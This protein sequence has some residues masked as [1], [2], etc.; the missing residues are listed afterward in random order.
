MKESF[1]KQISFPTINSSEMNIILEYIHVES[2]KKN[3]L[4]VDNI[5]EVYFAADY[6]KI[7]GLQE[8]IITTVKNTLEK[9]Y[10]RNYSP[11]LLSKVAEIMPLSED[12]ALHN[13]LVK[14]IASTSLNY[15]EFGRLSITALEYL[16]YYTHE[17][18]IPFAT[19]EYEVF[20]YSAILAA[21][22]VSDDTYNTLMEHLPTLGQVEQ[23]IQV[24]NKLITNHKKVAKELE[25]LV[26]YID[27]KRMEKEQFDV[28]KPLKII[29]D[30]II[31]H[32]SESDLNNIRGIPIY[33]IKESDLLWDESAC[34]SNLIIENNGKV[35]QGSDNCRVNQSVRINIALENKG[36]YEWDVIIEKTCRRGEYV[37][38]GV[39]SENFDYES[40]AVNQRNGWVLGSNGYCIYSGSYCPSFK[41]DDD[42]RIT[43]HLDMNKRTCAF[44][45]NGIKY[46]EVPG[47]NNLPSKLYPLVSLCRYARIRIQAHQKN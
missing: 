5:V 9:N 35:V 44:T 21:K 17:K 25:P 6:F 30:E 2:V 7:Q 34:G 8:L 22:L 23:S 29:P 28:I 27:F 36:I 38:V 18:E 45:V 47:W 33:R 12:N 11:E 10:T 13:L 42:V 46:Q 43:V 41:D 3:S 31:Q 16:L 15:I 19:P 14:E 24:E 1:E 20:R 4:T 39:C 37:W 40:W 26:E 32:N